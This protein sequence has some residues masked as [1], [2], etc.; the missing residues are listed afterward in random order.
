MKYKNARWFA[1]AML[2][3]VPLYAQT[4]KST[5]GLNG[6][7]FAISGGGGLL[8]ARMASGWVLSCNEIKAPDELYQDA[9]TFFQAS[10]NH[11][12]QM[13]GV[14]LACITSAAMHSLED[15]LEW[16]KQHRIKAVAFTTDEEG[17][18]NLDR[19]PVGT[20]MIFAYGQS[21]SEQCVWI[22]SGITFKGASL[23]V[24]LSSPFSGTG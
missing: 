7:V 11:R 14:A 4:S 1:L 13:C 19:P 21:G 15:T 5:G 9:C 22:Q 23:T 10:L 18:F 16:T 2:F 8:P 20:M 6:R 24:K 17:F 3:A 12:K